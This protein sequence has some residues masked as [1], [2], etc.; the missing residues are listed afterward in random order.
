M[1]GFE[2]VTLS[3]NGE[4]FTVPAER[5]LIL[6]AQIEDAL[7]GSSGEQAV[8]ILMRPG[9]PPYSRLAAAFGSALRYAGAR[10]SDEEI[11]LAIVE[12][13]AQCNGDVML[14]VRNAVLALLAIIARP[15]AE[16]LA[17][18]ESAKKKNKAKG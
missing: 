3:W 12:A 13:L 16:T 2:D 18:P 9:G 5:Q 17:A 7:S 10:V 15:V 1:K 8:T 6:I 4:E 11:Y 14:E